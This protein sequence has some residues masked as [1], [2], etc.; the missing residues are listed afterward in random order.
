MTAILHERGNCAE[1]ALCAPSPSLGPSPCLSISR[2]GNARRQW[3]GACLFHAT[4]VFVAIP[5]HGKRYGG[6]AGRL[7][8]SAP[9]SSRVLPSFGRHR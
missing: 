1:E 8:A 5:T 6:Y 7:L 9:G 2:C 3:T 4:T